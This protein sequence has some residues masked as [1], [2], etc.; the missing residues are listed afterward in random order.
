MA[1]CE[2]CGKRKIDLLKTVYGEYLCEDC[3]DDYLFTSE[4]KAEYL[5]GIAREDYPASSFDA[6]FLGFA[7]VQWKKN[8]NLF[9][10]SD[11]AI[12]AIEAKLK[13]HGLL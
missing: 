1:C 11:E 5:L 12:E 8:R 10:M 7:A 9:D 3:W 13:N 2:H 6:D 4:A